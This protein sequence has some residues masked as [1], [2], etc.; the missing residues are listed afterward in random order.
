MSVNF[1]LQTPFI[2][3]RPTRGRIFNDTGIIDLNKRIPT[4]RM[5]LHTLPYLQGIKPRGI[6][7]KPQN[8]PFQ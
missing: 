6:P 2:P 8:P 7:F 4:N 3:L 5:I 1:E